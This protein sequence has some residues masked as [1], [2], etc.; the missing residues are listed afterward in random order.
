MRQLENS[1]IRRVSTRKLTNQ[2]Y[3]QSYEQSCEQ[4]APR[5]R[6]GREK[7]NSPLHPLIEKREGKE[8][9]PNTHS[10]SIVRECAWACVC[11]C[12]RAWADGRQF[13][14]GGA[15]TR[16]AGGGSGFA[17][18]CPLVWRPS[19]TARRRAD[20][21]EGRRRDGGGSNSPTAPFFANNCGI[22]DGVLIYYSHFTAKSDFL[23]REW[24]GLE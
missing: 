16:W 9:R 6:K 10:R 20:G 23:I 21:G 8:N 14:G 1:K 13:V 15:S 5:E 2:S 7:R 22:L 4:A 18:S 17:G 19:C 12:A 11:A 3:E 24:Y